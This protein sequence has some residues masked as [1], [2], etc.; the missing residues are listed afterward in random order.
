MA[1]K[2]EIGLVDNG[3]SIP[4]ALGELV[5]LQL[6]ENPT[7]GYRW[8]VETAGSLTL[9]ADSFAAGNARPGVGGVRRFEWRVTTPGTHE[10]RLVH[11]REWE[12]AGQEIARFMVSVTV[13]SR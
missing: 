5:A 3:R 11:R 10:L 9:V 1:G 12:A 6:P 13:A 4:V 8:A 2:T 7:T